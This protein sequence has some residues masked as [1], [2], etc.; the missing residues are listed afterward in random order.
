MPKRCTELQGLIIQVQLRKLRNNRVLLSL[1]SVTDFTA[2]AQQ[3]VS[4]F[5]ALEAFG[6]PGWL[7]GICKS[8]H[9]FHVQAKTIQQLTLFVA[10][11]RRDYVQP[12]LYPAVHH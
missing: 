4:I 2:S 3:V 8:F 11:H 12:G 9:N 7:E 6:I 5:Y 1:S 10:T